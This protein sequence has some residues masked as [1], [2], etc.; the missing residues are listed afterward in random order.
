MT[1]AVNEVRRARIEHRVLAYEHEPGAEAYGTEAATVLGLEPAR[2]FKTLVA[3]VDG[4]PVVGLVPVTG[5][6]DLKALARAAGG[7][8]ADLADPADAERWTGYVVGGISP[9]GQRRRLPTYVDATI[10][11][12]ELVWVSA[13]RRGLELELR[14]QDLLSALGATTAP[15]AG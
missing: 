7:K 6:L 4:R 12:G 10:L 15:L 1:P 3:V 11:D 9:F 13:G 2:V 5:R 14:S 8:R